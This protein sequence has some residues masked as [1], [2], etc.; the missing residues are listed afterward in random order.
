MDVQSAPGTAETPE[1]NEEFQILREVKHLEFYCSRSDF[2]SSLF[3]V[4][5]SLKWQFLGN[6]DCNISFTVSCHLMA[7][8]LPGEKAVQGG[9]QTSITASKYQ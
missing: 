2:N 1:V 7:D 9:K 8:N 5:F 6:G 4:L 3:A